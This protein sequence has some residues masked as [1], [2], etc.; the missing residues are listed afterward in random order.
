MLWVPGTSGPL[1]SSRVF[2]EKSQGQIW[3]MVL[4]IVVL[5]A[6]SIV[7][8]SHLHGLSTRRAGQ[9]LSLS[10]SFSN[11]IFLISASAMVSWS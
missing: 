8:V 2:R 1:N 4:Y 9:Q 7:L 5:E 3:V 11:V 10:A 6:V